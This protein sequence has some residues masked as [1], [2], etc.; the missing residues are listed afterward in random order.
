MRDAVGLVLAIGR[1]DWA[2]YRALAD[3]YGMSFDQRQLVSTLAGLLAGCDSEL[4]L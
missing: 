1:Q 2:G 3:A 4:D